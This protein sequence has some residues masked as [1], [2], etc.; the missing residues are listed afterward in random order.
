MVL[1]KKYIVLIVSIVIALIILAIGLTYYGLY[2]FSPTQTNTT[3]SPVSTNTTTTTIDYSK[4][5]KINNAYI[6]V[7]KENKSIDSQNIV[8]ITAVLNI[9]IENVGDYPFMI[10]NITVDGLPL[11]GF[12]SRNIMP[13]QKLEF[14][15][16]IIL[17]P[18]HNDIKISWSLEWGKNTTHTVRIEFVIGGRIYSIEEN[19]SVTK[20]VTIG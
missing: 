15:H 12:S 19:V 11:K 2:S 13:R 6:I 17:D 20:V 16:F 5:L 7:A 14:S 4:W 3:S 8:L 18:E 10:L 1:E 9:K